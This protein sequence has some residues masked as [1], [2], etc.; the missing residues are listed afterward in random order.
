MLETIPD[1][2]T[3]LARASQKTVNPLLLS[4]RQ[5]MTLRALSAAGRPAAAPAGRIVHLVGRLTE[6]VV[7]FLGPATEALAQTGVD[8]CVVLRQDPNGLGLRSR[9]D[10]RVQVVSTSDEPGL[11]RRWTSAR[12][13]YRQVLAERPPT[14]VHLHGVVSWMLGAG[15]SIRANPQVRLFYSPHGA[16]VPGWTRVLSAALM[17]SARWLYGQSAPQTIVN[18]GTDGTTV[19]SRGGRDVDLIERPV[20]PIFLD[21]VRHPA[22]RPLIVTSHRADRS[23]SAVAF[24]QL[25]VLL[26]DKSLGMSFNWIGAPDADSLAMLKASNVGVFAVGSDL[27][28]AQRLCSGWVYLDAGN[29][30]G[31]AHGLVEAMALGLPCVAM[32]N[33]ASRDVIRHRE[34]GLLCRNS[35]EIRAAIAELI[36]SPD[37]RMQLG[38]AAREATAE[39]FGEGKFRASLLSAYALQTA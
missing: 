27:E 21:S 13:I 28:R 17:W 34:T 20:S 12:E 35:T 11:L 16:H 8:Q 39:R 31:F 2:A 18:H 5:R 23:A 7:V 25:A 24:A 1:A 10:A 38:V 9:L 22:R 14:A 33:P 37:L 19:S 32:D 36:D 15:A 29:G 6:A 4:A 26:G 30:P 3:S